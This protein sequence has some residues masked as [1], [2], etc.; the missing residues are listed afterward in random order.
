MK[1]D[2]EDKRISIQKNLTEKL[3]RNFMRLKHH[4]NGINILSYPMELD[5]YLT[6]S[7]ENMNCHNNKLIN[8]ILERKRDDEYTL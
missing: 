3:I 1:K 7:I 5:E 4:F 6:I 2:L 8:N